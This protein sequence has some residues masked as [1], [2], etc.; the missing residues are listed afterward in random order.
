MRK[1]GKLWFWIIA[2]SWLLWALTGCGKRIEQ[3]LLEQLELEQR[4]TVSME[5]QENESTEIVSDSELES[6][7]NGVDESVKEKHKKNPI[8]EISYDGDANIEEWKEYTYDSKGNALTG[9]QY[10]EDGNLVACFEYS[11]MDMA[12]SGKKIT[13]TQMTEDGVISEGE[14]ILD[15]AGNVLEVNA[16]ITF[17]D[18]TDDYR[19]KNIFDTA[20]NQVVHFTGNAEE[21]KR[22]EFTYDSFGNLIR[23]TV[24]DETGDLI[25]WSEFV[26]DE[27]GIELEM[28]DY[29]NIGII[30][31][32]EKFIYDDRGN[33]LEM[34]RV[35]YNDDGSTENS[36]RVESSYDTDGNQ[37][38]EVTYMD[39]GILKSCNYM[40]DSYGNMLT[41]IEYDG[42]G[43]AGYRCEMVY[44]GNGNL[45][46]KSYYYNDGSIWRQ[47]YT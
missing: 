43:N 7:D 34:N 3:K 29:D 40:Y 6:A 46:T 24:Y 11:Y 45:L 26:Y 19:D 27:V 44:D 14:T 39:N 21:L 36:Y 16:R 30:N 12:D 15:E 4:S 35:S 25:G 10:K 33:L 22:R 13:G 17:G 8:K 38:T 5:S 1:Y 28:T 23:Y 20:G 9:K 18:E 37:K 2:I 47:E 41:E 31:L 42:D 32:S